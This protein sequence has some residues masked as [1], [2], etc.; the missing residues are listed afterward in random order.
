MKPSIQSW[1]LQPSVTV[2]V[3]LNTTGSAC[4]PAYR[5]NSKVRASEKE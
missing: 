3:R 2:P 1:M 4:E 5:L